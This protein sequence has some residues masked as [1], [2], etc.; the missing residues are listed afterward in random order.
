MKKKVVIY[1]RLSTTR[2]KEEGYSIDAQKEKITQFCHAAGHEVVAIFEEDFSA[3][4]LM[5]RPKYQELKNFVRNNEEKI[6]NVFVLS[7]NRLCRNVSEALEEIEWFKKFGVE[8]NAVEQWLD[9][10]VPDSKILLNIYLIT[11]EIEND[12][13]SVYVEYAN[14]ESERQGELTL[15][16][17]GYKY[18][19]DQASK[20]IQLRLDEPDASFV[21][22]AFK[23]SAACEGDSDST[24]T[25]A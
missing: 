2:Q 17:K 10:S 14:R 15:A 9:W 21:K 22:E 20:K 3:R 16:P 13:V 11:P 6:S 25:S 4:D 24:P 5:S 18:Q 7:W 1:V 12:K 19:L 23:K 8:V